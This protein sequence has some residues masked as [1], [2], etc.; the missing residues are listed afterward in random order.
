MEDFDRIIK[1]QVAAFFK[2][3]A[4]RM[5]PEDMK[6]VKA[7]YRFA[8]K[9][10]KPEKRHSG[11]P[12]IIHPIAVARII[13]EELQLG[14]NSIMAAFLH[15]VVENTS[16]T[17]ED[18]RKRFDDDVAFLVR[19]VTKEKKEH[20]K[21][22]K[23]LDNFKQMLDSVQYDIRAILIKLADRLHNMRTLSSLRASKQ[24]KIA[25]ET[26][27]FYAPLA[28]RLGL[29]D[30]KTE[31]QNLSF[32]YR[33]PQEYAALEEFLK[34]EETENQK[35]LESFTNKI[36]NLL[37]DKNIPVRLDVKYRTPY[38]LWFN[39]KKTGMDFRHQ[40]SK[41]VIW[42]TFP[43]NDLLSEKNQ[44]LRIYS[45]L[46]DVL[47]EK[48]NSIFNYIDSPKE[49]GYQSFHVKLLN[50]QGRW[51]DIHISSERMIRKSRLGCAADRTDSNIENWI[52]KFRSV[53]Q[54]I[55]DYSQRG[56]Y[57]QSVVSQFYNDDIL[58]FTPKGHGVML[59]Q[60]ATA[61]DFAY[62]IHSSIGEHAQYARVNGKL[63]SIKTV[64]RRGDC[65]EIGV[66]EKISP[67]PDWLKHVLTYKAK[68]SLN[69]QLRKIKEIPYERCPH[70][71]PLPGDDLTGFQSGDKKIILHKRDCSEAIMLVSQD[72]DS[73]VEVNF[74]KDMEILYPV[75]VNI[76]AVDRYHLLRELVDCITE[77]LKLSINELSTKT[78]DEIVDCTI[79]FSIH[80]AGELQEA[81]SSIYD[82]EG[83]DDVRR[84]D[85]ES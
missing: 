65:V 54:D 26:D 42:L 33:C 41:R 34:K 80:S 79:D 25:G 18:I 58:V 48:P 14:A 68:R 66:N 73:I 11:E 61:L 21:M 38:S 27:Y 74:E 17:V 60:R 70:C 71:H 67:K 72:G 4:H 84:Q 82:V 12:Y 53:L 24:M 49:N 81:I 10:H 32:H 9:A 77:K 3:I 28:N 59:P 22:S 36:R 2:A 50:K 69:S 83:V 85:P 78:V 46:T 47:K 13:G 52:F 35:Q 5:T 55:A 40:E 43:D 1:E 62:E 44:C 8:R 31:L 51:E 23:Q 30:I 20:Y 63:C 19:V 45:L 16:Y 57:I 6:R 37:S 75:R 29:Y 15:D 64:L 76:K 39:M 7:A 56:G